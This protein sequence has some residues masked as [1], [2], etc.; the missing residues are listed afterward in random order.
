MYESIHYYT[1]SLVL[2]RVAKTDQH[3]RNL[4]NRGIAPRFYLADGRLTAAICNC[5]LWLR[6]LN[7]NI[8]FLWSVRNHLSDLTP[9][10]NVLLDPRSVCQIAFKFVERFKDRRQTE[11]STEKCV[12]IDGIDFA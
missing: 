5:R 6:C 1:S 4:V 12:S 3:Q 8:P 2:R 10:D 9:A 11:H 7:A